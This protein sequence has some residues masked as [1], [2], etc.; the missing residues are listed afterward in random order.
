MHGADLRALKYGTD[1]V[2]IGH[3][4]GVEWLRWARADSSRVNNQL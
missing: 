2:L 1:I 3:M 4:L